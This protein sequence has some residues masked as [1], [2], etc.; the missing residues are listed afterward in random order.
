VIGVPDPLRGQII[1]AFVVTQP[2]VDRPAGLGDE[3]V[4][5]VKAVC[6]EHQFPR[7]I[8]FV[9]AL[10]KTETGKIQ[11]FLLRQRAQHDE[12]ST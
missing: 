7:A 3:L 2:G 8:E 9:E 1:K 11:R 12:A 4:A 6:G 5:L 10:P